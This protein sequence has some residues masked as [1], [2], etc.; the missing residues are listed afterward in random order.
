MFIVIQCFSLTWYIVC[1]VYVYLGTLRPITITGH[2]Y[3][4]SFLSFSIP[5]ERF[6]PNE[7]MTEICS[8]RKC[9][10]NNNT[11]LVLYLILL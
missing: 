8:G 5:P 2:I 6:T 11:E 4:F 10:I 7:W 9:I 3:K 1:M